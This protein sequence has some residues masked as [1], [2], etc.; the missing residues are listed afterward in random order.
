MPQ[1]LFA[2]CRI[3]NELRAKRVRLGKSVQ[4][5]VETIFK[6]QEAD[7]RQGV[8]D[9]VSFDGDWKPEPNEFLTIDIPQEAQIFVDA[10]S[11]NAVSVPSINTKEFAQ[12]GIKALFTGS[13]NNGSTKVLIQQFSS[14]QMLSNKFAL[15]LKGDAFR[16]LDDQAFT[17]DTSLTCI[18]ED[19]KLKF[20]SFHKM[21]SIVNLS[22][23]YREATETE[24]RSFA[25]HPTFEVADTERFLGE[26]DQTIRKLIH[27]VTRMETL[28][29]YSAK[30][31][32][33]AA[34]DVKMDIPMKKRRIVMPKSRAEIKILLHFLNDGLYE[35]PLSKQRYVTNSKK[36]YE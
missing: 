20:K 1:N 27:S 13:S 2:A 6:D 17:L 7:F 12:E 14:R 16:R 9:E 34:K 26:S 4:R 21:R 31:I 25:E 33:A 29:Q 10:I 15:V 24:I 28:D 30:E 5:D 18:L 11:S 8:T 22:D 3:N 19:G 36:R 32:K 23:F 35:A